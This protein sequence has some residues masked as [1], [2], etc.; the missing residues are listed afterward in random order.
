MRGKGPI[1]PLSQDELARFF[2]APPSQRAE[3]VYPTDI[4]GN[5]GQQDRLFFV[6]TH[7]TLYFTRHNNLDIVQL[8][9]LDFAQHNNL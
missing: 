8:N 6:S 4:T 5:P 1:Y 7:K 9:N 2:N 3:T